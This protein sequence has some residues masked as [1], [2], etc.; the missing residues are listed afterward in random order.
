MMYPL[1]LFSQK[2]P[3]PTIVASNF[4]SPYELDLFKESRRRFKVSGIKVNGDNFLDETFSINSNIDSIVITNIQIIFVKK[5]IPY[6]G[7]TFERFNSTYSNQF[8]TV[9]DSKSIYKFLVVD[10]WVIKDF[11]ILAYLSKT[12]F[13][14]IN[15]A[16]SISFLINQTP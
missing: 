16:N 5:G 7:F 12:E 14:I 9:Y 10:D 15:K 3:L 2:D 11:A 6:K 4:F 13:I 1:S 8:T